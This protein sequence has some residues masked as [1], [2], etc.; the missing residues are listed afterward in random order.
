[1][2]VLTRRKKEKDRERKKAKYHIIYPFYNESG[3]Y[4]Y[5]CTSYNS[6][7]TRINV[8]LRIDQIKSDPTPVRLYGFI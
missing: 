2:F 1:M 6:I 5:K 8:N 4:L 3:L 7:R